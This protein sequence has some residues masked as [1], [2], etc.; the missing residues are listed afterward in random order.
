MT[1]SSYSSKI[2]Q[3]TFILGTGQFGASQGNTKVISNLRVIC[4]V[5][6]V[7]DPAKN[8]CKLQIFGM[9]PAD[10]N[11]LSSLG[12]APLAVRKNLIKVDAGDSDGLSTVYQGEITG[13][14]VN[15]HR[16]P[17]LNFEVH[18]VSGYYPSV[19]PANPIS[20]SGGV[21]VG[22]IFQN[23]AQQMGY[24]FI[25][26]GVSTVIQNPYLW[27]SAFNQ[28]Q[29]LAHAAGCEFGVDDGELFIC[30]RNVYRANM[31][32][33][34]SPTT[35]MKDYPTFDKKGLEVE[36]QFN[37]A[38]RLGGQ[39]RI[40]GSAVSQANGV[41]RIHGLEHNLVSRNHQHG[42]W[43]TKVNIAAGAKPK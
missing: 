37:P 13:A 14:W 4:H 1:Q 31:V 8:E 42:S 38:I 41:W 32:A 15:Y 28:A 39:L 2:I 24:S 20:M 9:L 36:M 16:P 35:G 19:A 17:D 33:Y 18:A 26:N 30:P 29:Q 40:S 10:M 27:G 12:Y 11:L 34:T 21:Q 22:T 6:K 7:G 5:K 25:N 3:V 23:L 43:H